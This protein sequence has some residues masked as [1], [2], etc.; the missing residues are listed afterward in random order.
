MAD[1]SEMLNGI[2]SNPQAMQQMMALA[3]VWAYRD[4]ADSLSSPLPPLLH[5]R[6]SCPSSQ[7]SR[8]RCSSFRAFCRCPNKWVGTNGSWPSSR[9]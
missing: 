5:P 8:T 7:A 1:F 9:P 4:R 6:L 3:K 2:L